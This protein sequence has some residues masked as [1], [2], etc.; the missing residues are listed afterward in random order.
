MR[1]LGGADDRL[2]GVTPSGAEGEAELSRHLMTG[3]SA[4]SRQSVASVAVRA[5]E[6][7]SMSPKSLD[8]TLRSK[9]GWRA[10][11][12]VPFTLQFEHSA[13]IRTIAVVIR[14]GGRVS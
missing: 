14:P 3:S 6:E 10:G 11:D 9:A 8:V 1:N 7:L 4:A 5:G 13:S 2:V 12:L